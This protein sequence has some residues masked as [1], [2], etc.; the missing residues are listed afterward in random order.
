[1]ANKLH[2]EKQRFNDK[3]A[4]ALLGTGTVGLLYA[5][6][7]SL[8][9]DPANYFRAGVFFLTA[10]ALGGWLYWLVKLQLRVKISDKSI[11]FRMAPLHTTNRK[12]KWKEVKD[13]SIVRTPKIAQW[14][15]ANI[16][17]GT[18]SSFSLSGRNGLSIT[19]KDGR[20]YFIGCRDVD[21]LQEAM[22]SFSV[23]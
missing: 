15:G 3:V 18:E 1:M 21:G 11:K 9:T 22:R 10:F 19:T 6:V 8:L 13:C 2:E 12:I 20:K 23:A 4:M 7:S 14:H 5:A 17:Y 16:S